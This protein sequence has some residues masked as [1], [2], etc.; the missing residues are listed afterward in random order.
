MMP[1]WWRV[2]VCQTCFEGLYYYKVW[3]LLNK[4]SLNLS[5][6]KLLVIETPQQ[7]AKCTQS[8]NE[9]E[10]THIVP[11]NE[12]RNLGIVRFVYN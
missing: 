1:L 4:L 11:S 2:E 5:K 6:T 3:L 8:V 7:R 10:D 9:V 12:V